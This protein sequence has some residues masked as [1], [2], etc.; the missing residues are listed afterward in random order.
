V[1][2]LINRWSPERAK[3]YAVSVLERDLTRP[4][5]E[6]LIRLVALDT[7]NKTLEDGHEPDSQVLRWWRIVWKEMR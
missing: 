5:A 6:T 4:Q 2:R 3:D 7:Y 1:G